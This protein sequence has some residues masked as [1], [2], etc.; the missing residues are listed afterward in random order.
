MSRVKANDKCM[1]GFAKRKIDFG[2]IDFVKL[3]LVKIDLKI[4][5]FILRYIDVKMS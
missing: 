5:H 4:N 1:F 3:I 2:R